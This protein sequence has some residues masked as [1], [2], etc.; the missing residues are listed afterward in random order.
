MRK[1]LMTMTIVLSVIL[2]AGYGFAETRTLKVS[3]GSMGGGFYPIG[4]GIASYI[5]K[6]VPNARATAVT[7]GGVNENITRLN[8]KTA[9]IGLVSS[10]DSYAAFRGIP[11]YKKKYD[12][13]F[14]RGHKRK[15]KRR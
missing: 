12:K 14:W 8:V 11:P 13:W 10:G 2:L 6:N 1:L 5:S 3:T 9:D 4:G 7:S 15:W